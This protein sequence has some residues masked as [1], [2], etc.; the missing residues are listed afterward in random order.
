MIKILSFTL[1][2]AII[3]IYLKNINCELSLLLT[4]CAG[5][6]L[7]Y[8]L[9]DYL[10]EILSFINQLISISGID[11]ELYIIIFKITSIGYIVEFGAS[12]LQDFG[13]K[14]MADKLVFAGKIII[15]YVALPIIYSVFNLITGLLV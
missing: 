8:F 10:S 3:I 13:L 11:K 14:N 9:L 5:C 7:L 1:I 12:T 15:L 6:L 4:I 2:S